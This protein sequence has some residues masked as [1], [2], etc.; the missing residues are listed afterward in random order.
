MAVYVF[1]LLASFI[2][3]MQ[4][5]VEFTVSRLITRLQQRAVEMASQYKLGEVL[6]PSEKDSVPMP[7]LPDLRSVSELLYESWV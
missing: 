4:F 3:G 2:D 1:R 6:F 7:D 5:N